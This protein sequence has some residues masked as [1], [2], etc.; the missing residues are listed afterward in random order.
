MTRRAAMPTV[1][2]VNASPFVRK[3]RVFLAEKNVSYDL[4]PVLPFNVSDDF[5]K[6]SPLGKV[7]A[8]RDGDVT[9]CD[10]SVICHYLEKI[11]PSPALYPSDPYEFA[12]ALWFEEFGDGGI[13]SVAGP[14]IFLEKVVAPVFFNRATD[15]AVVEKAIKEEL[16]PLFNYLEG[17]LTGDV[18]VGKSFSIAD[19]GVATHFV[20]LRHAGVSVDAGRWPKL[21]KYIAGVHARPSFKALIEEEEATFRPAA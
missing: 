9:L 4:D 12:R 1:L 14:K 13:V 8:F 6:L 3:V 16:P 2:G 15:E 7:P 10:S 21:A 17:E 18:L 20:N 5:K 19:I 11:H